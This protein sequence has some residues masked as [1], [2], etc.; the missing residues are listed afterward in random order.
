METQNTEYKRL[1]KDEYLR[2]IS[3]FANANGGTLYIGIDDNGNIVGVDN[4][5]YLLE[6]LPNKAVQAT[7][8]V[9]EINLLNESGKE[10]LAIQVKPS[11][12]PVS[13]NGK[14]Y[15]RSGSTLQELN[16]T[17]LTEFLT[18]RIPQTEWDSRIC[19][20]ADMSDI[21]AEAVRY[22]I[23]HAIASGRMPKEAE[24]DNMETVLH[25]LSLTDKQGRLKNAA[26]LLFGK[27]PQFF[28]ITATFR[29]GRF[30]EDGT[31]LGFQD[32]FEGNILQMADNVLWKLRTK[33][34]IAP[35]HYEGVQRVET[36]EIS[37]DALREL[38]YNAIVHRDYTGAHTQMKVFN[39]HI[40]L[41]NAG[42]LPSNFDAEKVAVEHMSNPRNHLLANVF[43]RAGFIE[44]FGR[45][46]GKVCT[47]FEK[48][49]L[50]HPAFENFMGGTL[51]TIPRNP[52]DQD[53]VTNNVT[54]N[55]TK[56]LTDRQK[57]II[58]FIKDDVT[59]NVTNLSQKTKVA[60]R[61]V[62]RDIEVLK[63]LGII[64]RIGTRKTGYWKVK[65]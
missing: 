33:Y 26:I 40:R 3:G 60:M 43:Y 65:K 36:L 42:E 55:V 56:E 41:W 34:L 28:F 25:N 19:K 13:C 45:G 30:G 50:P 53:N 17:A 52:N 7:G 59:I 35:I 15:Q 38:V 27:K 18:S 21:D 49:N 39:R 6:N 12:Q 63:K 31:D 32:E 62:M 44:A 9:P 14:F 47:A 8:I 48:Q 23:R 11:E 37:E 22:F 57:L 61:T 58:D 51:V 1:W 2:Y 20:D 5:R 29:L 64:E 10:Y 4:A 16:G 46:I 54:N 24:N